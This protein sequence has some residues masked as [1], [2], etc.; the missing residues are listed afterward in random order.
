MNAIKK[1]LFQMLTLFH[2]KH[3]SGKGILRFNP[4][5]THFIFGNGSE[6][7]IDGELWIGANSFGN[8]GRSNIIRIDKNAILDV[9]GNFK[10]MYGADVILFPNSQFTVGNNSFINSDCKVRCHKSI[11]IG[12]DCKI[13]HDFIVMDSDVHY[14]AGDNHTEEVI[15]E[16]NV[17]I[18]TRVIVL[19]GAKIGQG[20]VVAAGAL[21]NKEYPPHSL[22]AGVPGKVIRTGIEW[23]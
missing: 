14:L 18:G 2:R 22:I 8:N 17:W 11:Q 16:D 20:S 21:V 6:I 13:S 10:L 23:R 1:K 15:I 3:I 5:L 4:R 12:K 9:E 19:S 7:R